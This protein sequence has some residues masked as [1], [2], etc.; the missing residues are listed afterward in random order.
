[1]GNGLIDEEP[2][3]NTTRTT[4][5]TCIT[6]GNRR[7]E[8]RL[9]GKNKN[10][11][12]RVAHNPRS[13]KP[14][15]GPQGG[16][17]RSKTS[18]TTSIGPPQQQLEIRPE[19]VHGSTREE[20]VTDDAGLVRL[21]AARRAQQ[22]I[23]G[24]REG[25]PADAHYGL[26]ANDC[27]SIREANASRAIR[28]Q[29]GASQTNGAQSPD[30]STEGLERAEAEGILSNT[31][32]K[33]S[34]DTA[35]FTEV[36]TPLQEGKWKR[37]TRYRPKEIDLQNQ[38]T[39]NSGTSRT[40]A[41]DNS[42]DASTA[43]PTTTTGSTT[44]GATARNADTTNK[45]PA[46][47]TTLT[48]SGDPLQEGRWKGKKTTH[49]STPAQLA[50][51]QGRIRAMCAEVQAR[52]QQQQRTTGSSSSTAAA[53][54]ATTPAER[55]AV[56]DHGHAAATGSRH[57]A[58]AV[59]ARSRIIDCQ[60]K[61]SSTTA[62]LEEIRTIDKQGDHSGRGN[63]DTA[64]SELP[65]VHGVLGTGTIDKS[66]GTAGIAGLDTYIK[67]DTID[68]PGD[69]NVSNG[70][71]LQI[72]NMINTTGPGVHN[73]RDNRIREPHALKPHDRGETLDE[74]SRTGQGSHH[75]H[76]SPGDRNNLKGQIDHRCDRGSQNRTSGAKSGG[77]ARG[78]HAKRVRIHM[79]NNNNEVAAREAK[80][81]NAE[82]RAAHGNG[83][84]TTDA[85]KWQPVE[86]M[87]I[88]NDER[89]R[90]E[91]IFETARGGGD[92]RRILGSVSI[93]VTGLTYTD[94]MRTPTRNIEFNRF[95]RRMAST[96]GDPQDF[97]MVHLYHAA[98]QHFGNKLRA[99][100]I[101]MEQRH[102]R[103]QRAASTT[104][105][106]PP[107]R[108]LQSDREGEGPP[109]R[110]RTKTRT[111]TRTMQAAANL[112]SMG[113]HPPAEDES[114][115]DKHAHARRVNGQTGKS[116]KSNPHD[117]STLSGSAHELARDC[118]ALCSVRDDRTLQPISSNPTTTADKCLATTAM[119]SRPDSSQGE[120]T[121]A[122]WVIDSGC[123]K[124][125]VHPEFE[126][127][128]F[129]TS[130]SHTSITGFQGEATSKARQSGDMHMHFFTEHPHE[131]CPDHRHQ[132]HTTTVE[133]VDNINHNLFGF[134]DM[135]R[136]G[137]E[138]SF[139]RR[140]CRFTIT[141]RQTG[142]TKILPFDYDHKSRSFIA[143]VIIAKSPAVAA[144]VVSKIL[145]KV[146]KLQDWKWF[147]GDYLTSSPAVAWRASNAM[148]IG[149][150]RGSIL[151]HIDRQQTNPQECIGNGVWIIPA[152]PPLMTSLIETGGNTTRTKSRRVQDHARPARPRRSQRNTQSQG[153]VEERT[154]PRRSQ[155]NTQS[156]EPTE[157]GDSSE[158]EVYEVSTIL[159]RGADDFE[160][161]DTVKYKVRWK[162]Y[163]PEHDTWETLEDLTDA[164]HKIDLFEKSAEHNPAHLEPEPEI[165][166]HTAAPDIRSDAATVNSETDHDTTEGDMIQGDGIE[167]LSET[168]DTCTK[169]TKAH[170]P[171]R[172]RKQTSL[173]MHVQL[174]HTG[175]ATGCVHC[176]ALKGSMRKIYAKVDPFRCLMPGKYFAGDIVTFDERSRH[177]HTYAWVGRDISTGWYLPIIWL[178]RKNDLTDKLEALVLRLRRGPMFKRLPYPVVQN[179]RMD[180]AGEQREDN[181]GFRQMLIRIGV[182]A[183]YSSPHDK[184]SNA[185]AEAAI[186]HLTVPAKAM[187][188]AAALPAMWIEECMEQARRIRNCS[189]MK[190]DLVTKDGSAPTPWERVTR[191]HISRAECQQV[192]HHAQPIG[193][194]AVIF[195]SHVKGSSLQRTKGRWAVYIGMHRTLPLFSNPWN[196]QT[197][198]C[199][200][201][202]IYVLKSGQGFYEFYGIKRPINP[203]AR[204]EQPPIPTRDGDLIVQIT[205][206]HTRMGEPEPEHDHRRVVQKEVNVAGIYV[207]PKG[208]GM[209]YGMSSEGELIPIKNDDQQ[210]PG[211]LD[212]ITRDI[213]VTMLSDCADGAPPETDQSRR[214][215]VIADI[216]N[217]PG[218]IVGTTL[219]LYFTDNDGVWGMHPGTITGVGYD[220]DGAPTWR[221][222]FGLHGPIRT[223]TEQEII[224]HVVDSF[225]TCIHG[226]P[227]E[228]IR[229][230]TVLDRMKSTTNARA[231]STTMRINDIKA[232][233]W[234]PERVNHQPFHHLRQIKGK[235]INIHMRRNCRWRLSLT[236]LQEPDLESNLYTVKGKV[237]FVH[238]C[239]HMGIE[240]K[241]RKLYYNWLGFDYGHNARAPTRGGLGFKFLNPWEGER[242]SA[243]LPPG[244]KL[245][246]PRGASWT[247][248]LNAFDR[249][250]QWRKHEKTS[251][252]DIAAMTKAE[253]AVQAQVF[254]TRCAHKDRCKPFYDLNPEEHHGEP[255]S[256][257]ELHFRQQDHACVYAVT[258]KSFATALGIKP[259][260]PRVTS[261]VGKDGNIKHPFNMSEARGRVDYKRWCQS[262]EKEWASILER[263]IFSKRMTID[264]ARKLGITSKPVPCRTVNEIKRLPNGQVDKWKSRFVVQGHPGHV[265]KGV[266]YW[267]TFSAAPNIATT[268]I[269]QCLVTLGWCSGSVDI[270]TA[271]LWGRLP[272]HERIAVILPHER[273]TVRI[274]YG[275]IYGMPQ[276]DRVYT[277]M[278]D[279]FILTT[280]NSGPWTCTKGEYDPCLFYFKRKLTNGKQRRMFCVIHTDDVDCVSE[281]KTDMSDLFAALDKRFK[282]KA[283]DVKFMLGLERTLSEDGT[284]TSI[285]Q[286]GFVDDLYDLYAKHMKRKIHPT[287]P[288]PPGMFLAAVKKEEQDPVMSKEIMNRGYQKV[289]GSLLW[290]QR[291][292]YPECSIGVQYL[293]R[294]MS[295]PTE[296]AW[297][298]AM[299]MVSYL[300]G[301]RD[302]GIKFTRCDKPRLSVYYD[303]SNKSDINDGV[304]C[305]GHVAMLLGGPIEWCARKLPADSPG[306]SAHHNEYMALSQA[307]KTT[308]WLRSLLIE[309]DFG[310]WVSGPTKVYGDNDAATQL[311]R[312]DI[313]TIQNR[314]YAKDAHFSKKAFQHGLTNPVR[315]PGT[316]NLADGLTKALPR[317]AID[318]L[319]PMLKGYKAISAASAPSGEPII[320]GKARDKEDTLDSHIVNKDVRLRLQRDVVVN[321]YKATQLASGSKIPPHGAT[322]QDTSK[323]RF[324]TTKVQH[325]SMITRRDACG[326]RAEKLSD[327]ETC[328]HDTGRYA[329]SMLEAVSN[330]GAEL[331][332][333]RD[334]GMRH[335]AHTSMRTARDQAMKNTMRTACARKSPRYKHRRR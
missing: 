273:G 299:H 335:D 135:M 219:H 183:E 181:Q 310:D 176:K 113:D 39:S 230:D 198:R 191:G 81:H 236:E 167:D 210:P 271:Y 278:R 157:N 54:T 215:S 125:F 194:P 78:G 308:Q 35:L 303:A 145:S 25:Y 187:L 168:M 47:T 70:G 41:L 14:K 306:Q 180:P 263:D 128:M 21:P 130:H 76:V 160:G 103:V 136:Q 224:H 179:L 158:D 320:K 285:T 248:W 318:K 126:K 264:E 319:T 82:M 166:D 68:K 72:L 12:N 246:R 67:T 282:V 217:D 200:D 309:M 222:N 313:L 255:T 52:G 185:H 252:E 127:Y 196:G 243:A 148:R 149:T 253:A 178:E 241:H 79:I 233:G 43:S 51:A 143:R 20:Q 87:M 114:N 95:T 334:R 266:H 323:C 7:D 317:A 277:E 2:L 322:K 315:V 59:R 38:G 19:R 42:E 18:A 110:A 294:Q 240:V 214:E 332:G 279:K 186:K 275:N 244:T 314:Y 50:A 85:S 74:G 27:I 120:W 305:A 99:E 221:T 91:F 256:E 239:D 298:G 1:M 100:C 292:C 289:V 46:D 123:T 172:E 311:A 228:R 137:Y 247:Q 231:V 48:E 174:G 80:R 307:S 193:S 96:H 225:V 251:Q 29:Q 32:K 106:S 84:T 88:N 73:T 207:V 254:V 171:S 13:Y 188:L 142:L 3:R 151:R 304:A 280:F 118:S 86:E 287:T 288:F 257:L 300:K 211:P 182:E 242:C 295:S 30:S 276:A 34:A 116:K 177:G 234:A 153:S 329:A 161:K 101:R 66:T 209:Q 154:P 150:N 90:R 267:K 63:I 324:S 327:V 259:T 237:N 258:A 301:A 104:S 147:T 115:A 24:L 140:G 297:R 265:T 40:C 156:Q 56:D 152:P 60:S 37:P 71:A 213:E 23:D 173:Q 249:E 131:G 22:A 133:S 262:W 184:R 175:D 109:K 5:S 189:P 325:R 204:R 138:A 98:H 107:E 94:N 134:A 17:P 4:S 205:D 162:G 326:A 31:T 270:E 122:E 102:H 83:S 108:H 220:D 45:P 163:G 121:Y 268:R 64:V 97:Y 119:C 117:H 192:L 206:L 291:N 159:A 232:G 199:K 328:Q 283:G 6:S 112:A 65:R 260:D 286:R 269:L 62:V 281:N 58:R 139:D 141:D 111:P 92:R 202:F 124:R 293:C 33:R 144:E 155:R 10:E 164:Q 212:A 274:L 195:D 284:T 316:E 250:A 218:S 77:R 330:Q 169:A 44:Q 321:K 11:K 16:S 290:A 9:R 36:N 227:A 302:Y 132:A 272:E 203:F 208:K 55:R 235:V 226:N 170:L 8:R 238:A 146:D 61:S 69:Y 93:H 312:E 197:L 26:A 190:R 28:P 333:D 296:E 75:E 261:L 129:N 229:G 201:Y 89:R 57:D 15:D 165:E 223:L 49:L 216:T 245:I 53:A 105:S 331:R